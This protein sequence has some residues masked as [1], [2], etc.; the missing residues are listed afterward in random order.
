MKQLFI[1]FLL[2]SLNATAQKSEAFRIDKLPEP[3]HYW[4]ILATRPSLYSLELGILLDK[5]WKFQSGDNPD[6]AK[7]NFDDSQWQSVNP[8]QNFHG[9]PNIQK[10]ISWFR[11]Y[12]QFSPTIERDLAMLIEQNGASEVYLNGKLV[13]KLGIV[14][15]NSKEVK[16]YNPVNLPILLHLDTT[17]TQVL[18]IRYA[19]QP[20]VHY[21]TVFVISQGMRAS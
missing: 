16:A 9:I 10:G 6:F 11:I 1:L 5:G 2:F 3:N 15:L 12:L 8:A 17:S 18:A 19:Q 4:G 21:S 20:N 14:S 7:I 13:K